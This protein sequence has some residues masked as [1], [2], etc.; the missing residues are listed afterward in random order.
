MPY[1]SG[2]E[3]SPDCPASTR[4]TMEVYSRID[5]TRYHFYSASTGV[6][7]S[8]RAAVGVAAYVGETDGILVVGNLREQPSPATTATVDLGQTF[9]G[10]ARV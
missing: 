3:L 8:N 9:L 6:A 7:K 5:W 1:F 2:W 4:T 10:G